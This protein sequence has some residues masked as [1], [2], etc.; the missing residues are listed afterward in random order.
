MLTRKKSFHKS[1]PSLTEI[2]N[3][4]QRH[5]NYGR[6][7]LVENY[8]ELRDQHLD[9]RKEANRAKEEIRILQ[10]KLN[11]LIEEKKR[12]FR[13]HRTDREIS[14]EEI[15]YDLEHRMQQ[16]NRQNALLKQKLH[17]M[18]IDGQKGRT[19]TTT[20]TTTLRQNR[21]ISSANPTV[22]SRI[23]SGLHR[24]FSST[25]SAQ[26][27]HQIN[28]KQVSFENPSEISEA[29]TLLSEAKNEI[30][31]LECLAEE[32]QELLESLLI[33]QNNRKSSPEYSSQ[34]QT[35]H[36]TTTT[37]TV[38]SSNGHQTDQNSDTNSLDKLLGQYQKIMLQSEASNRIGSEAK[39]LLESLHNAL[40]EERR[41]V[42][43]LKNELHL[44]NLTT[45]GK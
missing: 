20:M 33:E 2:D 25:V 12:H 16:Q 13:L 42:A 21:R 10:V 32:Q 38:S 8:L 3:N 5:N 4:L 26:N 19:T 30:L 36:L 18:Q 39:N 17:L 7:E 14:L 9:L 11:R 43:N 31:R 41:I 27:S 45:S 34:S 6:N 23:D 28:R 35:Y 15:V 37:T 22:Q 1:S 44:A 24:P 29:K 40:Q